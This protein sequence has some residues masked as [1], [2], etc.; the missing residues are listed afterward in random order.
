MIL[1]PVNLIG[2]GIGGQA[3]KQAYKQALKEA[4]KG[5][6]AKEINKRVIQQAQ[7]EAQQA[8]MGQ[9]IKKG[10]LYE[11]FIGAGIAT[12]QDAML[13]NTAINTGVQ[14]ELSLK[15]MAFSTCRF[16]IWYSIWWCIFLWWI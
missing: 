1:D 7:K 14:D 11:G 16:W 5:K 12:G 15:Q 8:A 6:I 2:V 4:L 10:A 3:A 13:Q 9:A